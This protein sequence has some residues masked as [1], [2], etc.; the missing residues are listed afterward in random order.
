MLAKKDCIQTCTFGL[1]VLSIIKRD[2]EAVF[3]Q[4][5]R[6]N[7]YTKQVNVYLNYFSGQFIERMI[8]GE[9][10]ANRCIQTA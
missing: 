3:G 5:F 9:G 2:I 7:E 8:F 4:D 6:K 1:E 10:L